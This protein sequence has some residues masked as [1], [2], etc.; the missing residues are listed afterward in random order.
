MG[1]LL[2]AQPSRQT[3]LSRFLTLNHS[4]WWSNVRE[5]RICLLWRLFP[6][7][8]CWAHLE[9]WWKWRVVGPQGRPSPITRIRRVGAGQQ[10]HTCPSQCLR[11]DTDAVHPAPGA[12]APE[13][14]HRPLCRAS[15]APADNKASLASTARSCQAGR[16]RL[17]D[18]VYA[19]WPLSHPAATLQLLSHRI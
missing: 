1:R 8:W 18:C 9:Q 12:G 6:H 11:R 2:G 5:N 16:A 17:M 15:Q 19:N 10:K 3:S 4:A 14:A 13:G 7:L